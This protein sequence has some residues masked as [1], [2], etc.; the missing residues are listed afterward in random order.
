[1]AHAIG[2][3]RRAAARA[4]ERLG[5]DVELPARP[6]R[7]QIVALSSIRLGYFTPRAAALERHEP[8][9]SRIRSF[10]ETNLGIPD[11]SEAERCFSCG[12]CTRC[13]T[14][15]VYCPEGVIERVT[16]TDGNN[17]L[18]NLDFCKGCG[19]CVAECPRGAMEMHPQ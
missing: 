15:L 14:C 5:E 1:V 3:G 13:D 8:V 11:S 18:V 4:L 6:A 7:V 17:Y 9:K 19:I 12:H 16:G 10:H 2:D